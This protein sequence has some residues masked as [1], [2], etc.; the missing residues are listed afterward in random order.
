[1][2]NMEK[3]IKKLHTNMSIDH[4]QELKLTTFYE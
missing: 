4:V 1:M 3:L 2:T